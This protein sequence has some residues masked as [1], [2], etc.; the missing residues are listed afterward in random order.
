MDNKLEIA[1]ENYN[2]AKMRYN[3]ASKRV[4]DSE[5]RLNSIKKRIGTLQRHLGTRSADMYR[6]GP[7]EFIA[8]LLGAADFE[9]FASTWDLLT[10]I[11][12]NDAEAAMEYKRAKHDAIVVQSQLKVRQA[13]AQKQLTAMQQRYA[14]IQTQLAQR[15]RMLHGLESEIA[16]LEAADEAA[17]RR[18]AALVRRT[19]PAASGGGS[20]ATPRG[21]AHGGVVGIAMRYLG[22]PY[23]WAAAGPSSFDCSGFTMYVYAQVGISL[24]HSSQAQYNCGERVSRADLQPGDLVFFGSPIHHVGIYVGGGN[25]IHAPHTGSVV[26]ISPLNRMD[27]VGAVRP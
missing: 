14:S 26:Q 7:T 16:Q 15:K 25:F 24:P 2:D 23:Q 18:A 8:M 4:S 21:A 1:T 22:Y 20:Y 19:V 17:S 11:S 5:A 10:D 6:N 13:D 3:A 12:Q 9:E 27:Y